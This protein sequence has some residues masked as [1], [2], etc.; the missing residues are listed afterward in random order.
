MPAHHAPLG[1]D[2]FRGQGCDS[3]AGAFPCN[4]TNN[5][6]VAFHGKCKKSGLHAINWFD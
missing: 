4:F 5:A 6:V 2:F 3:G 1:I